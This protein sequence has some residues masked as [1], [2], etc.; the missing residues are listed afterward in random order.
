MIPV[1]ARVLVCTTPVDMRKSFDSLAGVVRERLGMEPLEE[2]AL[3]VFVNRGHDRAK[4][5]WWT[6]TGY[7]LLAKRLH[8]ALFRWPSE[9]GAP[10]VVDLAELKQLLAGEPKR[11]ARKS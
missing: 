6:E 5:L 1:G 8:R 4:V 7:C 3:F 10:V 11:D 9:R 2:R